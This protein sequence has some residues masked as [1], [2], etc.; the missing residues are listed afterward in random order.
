MPEPCTQLVATYFKLD[1]FH[2]I[3]KGKKNIFTSKKKELRASA[4]FAITNNHSFVP[5]LEVLASRVESEILLGKI[6]FFTFYYFIYCPCNA[7][8]EKAFDCPSIDTVIT[9]LLSARAPS[10]AFVYWA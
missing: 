4:H 5:F 3:G 9:C 6:L 10:P 8:T 7:E 1:Q 2:D